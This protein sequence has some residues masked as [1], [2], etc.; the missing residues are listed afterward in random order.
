MSGTPTPAKIGEELDERCILKA[1]RHSLAEEDGT[2]EPH[3]DPYGGRERGLV[4]RSFLSEEGNNMALVRWN[5]RG[6]L[7]QMREEMDRLFNQF[8]RHGEGEEGAWMRGTWA[9]SVDIYETDDAYM[10]KAE[11][12]GF[13]K[14]DVQIE[15]HNNRLTLRGER[16][17]ETEAKEEQYHRRERAYGHFERS[18][19]LPTMTDADKVTA[20]FKHGILELRLPK[21]EAA[22][23]KRIAINEP[24]GARAGR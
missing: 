6:D 21:S 23:P 24:E 7:M 13:T 14:D 12:P 15:L 10:L 3:R 11:L 22:R 5:P 17:E 19:V 9:P 1:I 2:V 16:K 4:R 8:M 18:F 20:N